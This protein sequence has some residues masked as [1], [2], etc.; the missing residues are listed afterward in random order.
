MNSFSKAFEG[1]YW[2]LGFSIITVVV[3]AAYF[4]Y[5]HAHLEVEYKENL[6]SIFSEVSDIKASPF[7]PEVVSFKTEGRNIVASIKT[8][9]IDATNLGFYLRVKLMGQSADSPVSVCK[10]PIEYEYKKTEF[11]YYQVVCESIFLPVGE[12]EKVEVE[13]ARVSTNSV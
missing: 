11:I 12:I 2:G 8:K 5:V 1:F 3:V 9:N 13:L 7:N 4:T 10:Q 6:I